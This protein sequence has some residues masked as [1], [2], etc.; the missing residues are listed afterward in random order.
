MMNTK[1]TTNELFSLFPKGWRNQKGVAVL[2]TKP[3]QVQ[4]IGW[5]GTYIKSERA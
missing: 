3:Q 4:S 5:V 1:A 2:A